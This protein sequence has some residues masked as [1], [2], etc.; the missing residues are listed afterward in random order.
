MVTDAGLRRTVTLPV[1]I[2]RP[3]V[4]PLRAVSQRRW[5]KGAVV[6]LA[7]FAALGTLAAL[8]DNPLFIRMTPAGA[9]EILALAALSTV[10]GVYAALRLAACGGRMAGAGGIAGFLGI[11]CPVCNK[12]LLFIFGGEALLS[13][14]EPVRIYVAAAGALLLIGAV[15]LEYRRQLSGREVFTGAVRRPASPA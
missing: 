2:S 1:V 7:S 8:W 10:A 14:F 15:L 6:A 4:S 5:A 9:W 12:L 13:Y 11:A 3:A